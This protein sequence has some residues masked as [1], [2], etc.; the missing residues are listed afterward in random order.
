MINISWGIDAYLSGSWVDITGDVRITTAA[1][2]I[3]K[4][5]TGSAPTDR[6]AQTGT[7]S[8]ALDNSTANSGGK[9]GYYSP[10]NANCRAGFGIGTRLRFWLQDSG[11]TKRYKFHCKIVHIGPSFGIYRDRAVD[12]QAVDYMEYLAQTKLSLI[13]VQ[14]G[15]RVDEL[16]AT[17]IAIL[18]VA[19]QATSYA[20]SPTTLAFAMHNDQD[21]KTTAMAA[22]QKL[23]QSD[24]GYLFVAGDNTIGETLTYQS[25]YSRHLSSTVLATLNDSMDDFALE[26]N[27]DNIFNDVRVT[28]YPLR[29]DT[30][31]TT[32]MATAQSEFSIPQGGSLSATMRYRDPL[33]GFQRISGYDMVAPVAGTDYRFTA[34][35]SSGGSE[36]NP[37]ITITPTFGANSA[38]LQISNGGS[39]NAY[40]GGSELFQIR[41]RGVYLYD[42]FE[43]IHV[44][45]SSGTTYGKRTLTF[46]MPYQN[47]INVG[48]AFSVELLSRY[49][50]PTSMINGVRFAANRSTTFQDY[51]A[52]REIGDRVAIAETVTGINAQFFIQGIEYQIPAPNLLFVRWLL[53]PKAN[54]GNI[55][56]WGTN[57]GDS[58][59]WGTN[60]ADSTDWV[61]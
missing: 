48:D 1:V 38:L 36:L 29:V 56:M 60:S 55:G 45:E 37:Q 17:V 12:V 41:G 42:P 58:G 5:L 49:K 11:A 8:F 24:L 32:V 6:Q 18:A 28:T 14:L 15:K 43:A 54:V 44:D 27:V 9:L 57:A 34:I 50:L 23:L 33:G 39:V 19:P 3:K 51:G 2:S 26:R 40:S 4:G 21:E 16:I 52:Q 46:D 22:I 13:P 59:V 53:E 31:G 10:D 7:L 25:R 47:D 30:S 61:F 35:P 20:I